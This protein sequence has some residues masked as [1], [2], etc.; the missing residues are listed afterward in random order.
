[1]ETVRSISA[2]A[3]TTKGSDPPSSKTHFFKFLPASAAIDRPAR[4]EPVRVTP[5]TRASA[6]IEGTWLISTKTVVSTPAGNPARTKRSSM[7]RA[8]P[9]TL[10][11]CLKTTTLPAM[12]V[13]TA[14]RT[15]CHNGKFQGMTAKIAP[16]GS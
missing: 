10:C 14:M 15:T 2:E 5:T 9:G 8:H 3:A 6:M 16:I 11:A 1:M 12:M 7:Y 4:S 13:G